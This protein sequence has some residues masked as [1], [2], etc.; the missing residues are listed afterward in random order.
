MV[1]DFIAAI[2]D[3]RPPIASVDECR[4]SMELITGLYKSA[5]TGARVVF[6]IAQNDPWYSKIPPEGV[7]LR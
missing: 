3:G 2:R 7:A 4:R 6:P 1:S 5:M